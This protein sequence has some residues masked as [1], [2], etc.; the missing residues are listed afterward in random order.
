MGIDFVKTC[1]AL[2]F[3][4]NAT[5]LLNVQFTLWM[6]TPEAKPLAH[7]FEETENFF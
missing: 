3:T 6:L 1:Y 5:N 2:Q 7:L 4:S